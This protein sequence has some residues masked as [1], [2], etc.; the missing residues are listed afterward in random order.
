MTGNPNFSNLPTEL[1]LKIWSYT[2]PENRIIEIRVIRREPDVLTVARAP[3]P[4]ILHVNHESRAFAK[5]KYY[6]TLKI[7]YFAHNVR[8]ELSQKMKD[9]RRSLPTFKVGWKLGGSVFTTYINWERDIIYIQRKHVQEVAG[10]GGIHYMLGE[11][12]LSAPGSG[13]VKELKRLVIGMDDLSFDEED[14]SYVAESC[15]HLE[16]LRHLV[17]TDKELKNIGKEME[18]TYRENELSDSC[19]LVELR[20]RDREMT[21]HWNATKRSGGGWDWD[22]FS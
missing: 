17:V 16:S 7:P 5:A 14:L 10:G 3:I 22:W 15:G 21:G 13:T 2:I 19:F 6:D 1:R 4:P 9:K 18:E 8:P 11:E 12:V 20:M